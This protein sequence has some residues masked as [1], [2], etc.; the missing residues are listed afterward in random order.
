M[1]QL[2]PTTASSLAQLM[3]ATTSSPSTG[4]AGLVFSVVDRNGTAVFDHA[5]GSAGLGVDE[6]MT[7]EHSFW[8]A[9]CTKMVTGIACMQLVEKGL[10]ELDSV[11]CVEGLCPVGK[12]L[13]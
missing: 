9:S 6:K 1:V 11:Q 10:L 4:A 7:T 5:S 12:T 8:I 3:D 2:S 13:F